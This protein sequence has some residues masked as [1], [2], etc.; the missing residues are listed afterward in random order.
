MVSKLLVCRI[1]SNK[2]SICRVV[3]AA[4]KQ[5]RTA[6]SIKNVS[7]SYSRASHRA[8][9]MICA[10]SGVAMLRY[11][12]ESYSTGLFALHLLIRRCTTRHYCIENSKNKKNG[13]GG[14]LPAGFCLCLVFR[15]RRNKFGCFFGCSDCQYTLPSCS[16]LRR[17][18]S[19]DSTTP[20]IRAVSRER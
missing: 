5:Y 9:G 20:L 11:I 6:Y 13:F 3:L 15:T 7:S 14:F 17:T 1:Q 8:H 18:R 19:G 10:E 2:S 12:A 4:V 16:S